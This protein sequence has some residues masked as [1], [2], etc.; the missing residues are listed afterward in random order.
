MRRTDRRQHLFAFF[1]RIAAAVAGACAAFGVVA[2]PAPAAAFAGDP[3]GPGVNPRVDDR[4]VVRLIDETDPFA[5]PAFIAAFEASA[6]GTGITLTP[7]DE[8]DDR[9]IHLLAFASPPGTDLDA[10]ELAFAGGVFSEHIRWGE[11][12]YTDDA[13][14]GS[15]G[16]SG[17]TYVDSI[18]PSAFTGQY[19]AGRV[20]LGVA[21]ARSTGRGVVV[22]VLDTG[23]DPDHPVFAGALRPGIDLVDGDAEPWDT[24]D[25]IDQ[26]GDGEIDELAGHGTFVAGIVRLAAP[27]ATIMPIRVLDDEGNGDGWR[28][29]RG[30]YEAIDAGV[31][32]INV[33]IRSTYN[34][35][36][37]E[38]AAEEATSLGI[39]VVA[40]AG[41]FGIDRR[42]FP[43]AKSAVL[44]VVALDHL[45]RKAAFSSYNDKMA[46]AAPGD[47]DFA[48]NPGD[49]ARSVVGP[50][51][52][53]DY[54]AWEGTSFASP[55]VAGAA[56][57]I[58]GQHPEWAPN[59]FT[60]EQIATRLEITAADIS[61][62]NPGFD[63]DDLGAGRL[64]IGAAS[65]FGPV[66]PALGDLD[67]DG[68]VDF[69]DLVRLLLDWGLV[70]SS[71]DLDGSG[72]VALGDLL[73]LLVAWD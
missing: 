28:L 68:A 63:P 12:L 11:F 72:S 66:A 44:G 57:V 16:T 41:N 65:A 21:H 5:L 69:D 15:Q 17:S 38:D 54:G 73:K 62:A 9:G 22:A 71:A 47:T 64:D 34:A 27:D 56:A 39:V 51:P 43:A 42:E 31:E 53:G 32:V 40:A 29:I 7:I 60:A 20:G 48:V 52:G 14:E 6:V 58:R 35:Q 70:H 18:V 2:A 49:P 13:P 67:G 23:V 45:D 3:G 10:I 1:L 8:V 36:A 61:A 50:L 19:A 24:A 59:E 46:I 30:M 37:V 55:L 26:D 4:L 33:S 25:G